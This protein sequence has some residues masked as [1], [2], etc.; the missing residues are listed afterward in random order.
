MKQLSGSSKLCSQE[1]AQQ[2]EVLPDV[3]TA[4]FFEKIL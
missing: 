3:L 2:W 1:I 4:L